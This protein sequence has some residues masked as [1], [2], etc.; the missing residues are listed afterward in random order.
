MTLVKKLRKCD[1][2]KDKKPFMVG[3][4]VEVFYTIDED[5]SFI[6]YFEELNENWR[7]AYVILNTELNGEFKSFKVPCHFIKKVKDI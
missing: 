4:I 3:D 5:R 7:G 2:G 6:G 1:R